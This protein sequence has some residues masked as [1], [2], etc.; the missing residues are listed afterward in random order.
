MTHNKV[1]YLDYI[2]T[3]EPMH[4]LLS[5]IDIYVLFV[6]KM[7]EYSKQFSL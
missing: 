7:C 2:I 5:N 1:K 4:R 6:K 3:I